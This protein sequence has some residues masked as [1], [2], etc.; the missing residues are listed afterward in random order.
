VQAA[1]EFIQGGGKRAIIA[2]LEEVETA[3][4]GETGTSVRA[5]S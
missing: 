4:S 1:I 5:D 3:L 2:H